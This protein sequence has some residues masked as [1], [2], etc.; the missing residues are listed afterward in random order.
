MMYR[1]FTGKLWCLTQSWLNPF[2]LK[3]TMKII[4]LCIT[5]GDSQASLGL[6]LRAIVLAWFLAGD[7]ATG[8]HQPQHPCMCS[9]SCEMQFHQFVFSLMCSVD[10]KCNCMHCKKCL[11]LG[12]LIK[13]NRV[14]IYNHIT[15]HNYPKS[16]NLICGLFTYFTL[17]F[18]LPP[19]KNTK[20][21]LWGNRLPV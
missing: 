2:V 8:L 15:V 3:H 20:K 6:A 21:L 5:L 7:V 16:L 9:L 4:Y 17:Y 11:F 18:V 1:I 13:C 14:L 10:C 19:L 12:S